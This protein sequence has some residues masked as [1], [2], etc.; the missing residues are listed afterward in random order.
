MQLLQIVV[1]LIFPLSLFS[2]AQTI[3]NNNN[4]DWIN[5]DNSA[6]LNTFSNHEA[7]NLFSDTDPDGLAW[8]SNTGIS[9]EGSSPPFDFMAD[10]D[11]INNNVIAAAGGGGGCL[12]ASLFQT[13][14]STDGL[15]ARSSPKQCDNPNSGSATTTSPTANPEMKIINGVPASDIEPDDDMCPFQR[16]GLRKMAVC[17]S[18]LHG[19]VEED[20]VF[21]TLTLTGV[22]PCM[23][24]FWFLLFCVSQ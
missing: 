12:S 22:T 3:P 7:E 24:T 14:L 16:F 17:D 2:F 13:S 1:S 23:Y 18:G 8:N 21:G 9:L 10:A 11:I 15:Q 4:I 20:I 6:D 19:D 5:G